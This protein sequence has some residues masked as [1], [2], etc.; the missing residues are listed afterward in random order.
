MSKQQS[1]FKYEEA[2]RVTTLAGVR[3]DPIGR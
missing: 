3:G 2:A 1:V